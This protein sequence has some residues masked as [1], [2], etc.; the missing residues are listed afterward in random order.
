MG[1]NL[2]SMNAFASKSGAVLPTRAVGAEIVRV[3]VVISDRLVE[4]T[5]LDC[6]LA[7]TALRLV[8]L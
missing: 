6:F 5:G 2:P 3:A 4:D 8:E 1:R 7:M